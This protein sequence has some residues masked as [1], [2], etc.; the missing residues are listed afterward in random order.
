MM[1]ELEE[2]RLRAGKTASVVTEGREYDLSLRGSGVT[3][4]QSDLNQIVASACGQSVYAS[5]EAISHGFIS[6][7]GGHRLGLCGTVAE[8]ASGVTIRDY[9]SVNLR[10]AKECPGC[11]DAVVAALRREPGGVLMIGAPGSG[12]TTLLRDLIRQLSDWLGQRVGVA[13]ER[14]EIA[15]VKN[16]I[17]QLDV[18]K[19]TDVMSGGKKEDSLMRLLRSMNPEYLAMDEISAAG[20]LEALQRAAYCGVRLIATA[21]AYDREDLQRRKIFCQLMQSHL[22]AYLVEVK[23]DRTVL[24][25]RMA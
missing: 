22:F 24:I 14:G 5:A 9:S 23:R 20:D 1:R 25:E 16:G 18:G 10:I 19:R 13:D 17:P 11:A 6:I 3:V 8:T 12:K 2:I 7:S 4:T 21:H 15:A